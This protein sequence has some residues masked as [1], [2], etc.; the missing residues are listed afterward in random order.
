MHTGT[1]HTSDTRHNFFMVV[2]A[3]ETLLQAVNRHRRDTGH[4]GSVHIVAINRA[5][6]H[7]AAA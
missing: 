2:N 1:I 4:R 5:R 6:R 3:G 7:Q